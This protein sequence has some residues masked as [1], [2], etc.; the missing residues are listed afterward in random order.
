MKLRFH[1]SCSNRR[2]LRVEQNAD[3]T[4]RLIR[5]FPNLRNELSNP[6]G[7]G[8]A[9]VESK[10][11]GA[12]LNHLAQDFSI[13]GDLAQRADDFCPAHPPAEFRLLSQKQAGFASNVIPA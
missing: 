12:V 4:S 11:V 9:H 13:L 1:I 10:H 6:V 5:Q 8:V 3:G 2:P 7:I